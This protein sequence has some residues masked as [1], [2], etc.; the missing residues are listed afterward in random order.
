MIMASL[1]LRLGDITYAT[2]DDGGN[3][4]PD[5]RNSLHWIPPCLKPDRKILPPTAEA[6]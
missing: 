1:L 6:E 4:G 3:T 2:D 5:C